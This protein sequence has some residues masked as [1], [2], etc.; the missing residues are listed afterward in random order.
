MAGTS[1]AGWCR[2]GYSQPSAIA[3]AVGAGRKTACI[4]VAIA[5]AASASGITFVRAWGSAWA[6]R[7]WGWG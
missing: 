2:T 1:A 3:V 5:S 4:A 7:L 6:L